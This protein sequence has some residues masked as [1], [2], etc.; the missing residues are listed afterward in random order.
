MY[1]DVEAILEFVCQFA[2][3]SYWFKKN[4]TKQKTKKKKHAQF[5][6]GVTFLLHYV[7]YFEA[8]FEEITYSVHVFGGGG[9][10]I[11]ILP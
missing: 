3:A 11:C 5:L 10:L 9:S 6:F 4:K 1:Q 2:S 8:G 7:S